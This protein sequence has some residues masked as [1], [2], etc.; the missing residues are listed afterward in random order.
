MNTTTL[1]TAVRLGAVEAPN[2]LVMSP[3]TRMRAGPRRIPTPLMAEYYVQRATAGLIVTEATAASRTGNGAYVNT[4]GIYT[5]AHQ[6]KWAEVAGAV[7]DYG[8]KFLVTAGLLNVLA[9]VDAY[10]IAIGKKS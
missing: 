3:L 10:E 1:F 2:R 5:D 9:M 4:P 6:H 7:H 8:T